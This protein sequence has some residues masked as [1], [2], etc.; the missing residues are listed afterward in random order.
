M[1]TVSVVT[2]GAPRFPP[3]IGQLRPQV[4]ISDTVSFFDSIAL[5]PGPWPSG[6]AQRL[7]GSPEIVIGP[8]KSTQI[9]S[10]PRIL[11]AVSL[12]PGTRFSR[13]G[14][15]SFGLLPQ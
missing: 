6:G 3:H 2:G 12:R 1:L 8:A 4:D 5:T 13:D 7:D 9:L 14:E 10:A 15:V 11:S